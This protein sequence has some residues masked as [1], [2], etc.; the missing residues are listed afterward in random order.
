MR[1]FY[2]E[3]GFVASSKSSSTT[4]SPNRSFTSDSSEPGSADTKFSKP[5]SCSTFF[6]SAFSVFDTHRDSSSTS[7]KPHI[8]HGNGWTSA[9]KKIVAGGSMRRIQECVLGTGKT[10]ISNTPGDIWLL[11]ACYKISQDNSSG[12]AAATNALAAFNHD[13]C[14]FIGFDAIEDS[15]LTS[16]VSWGCMLRSSQMLVAQALLFH[17]LGRSWRKPLDKLINAQQHP[18]VPRSTYLLEGLIAPCHFYQRISR[19]LIALLAVLNL[20]AQ[21]SCGEWGNVSYDSTLKTN[22]HITYYLSVTPILVAK[23]NFRSVLYIPSL[24]AT[25]TF[26]QSLGILGGKPGASTYIVGVQDEDAFYLDPHE[27]QP[28]VNVSRDV[29]EANTSS[30]HCNVVRH[31]PLDFIDPSLAI[32]FY[33]RDKVKNLKYKTWLLKMNIQKNSRIDGTVTETIEARNKLTT[34]KER[35]C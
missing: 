31:I 17:R 11:G 28:V 16:D 2:C 6:A 8:R 10:G 19:G 12:D 21:Y 34:Q 15:K 35:T 26:P 1:P 22:N 25:F 7:E 29:V 4:D 20:V 33:C 5:S 14:S 3:R 9:V 30:Y 24:Q 27:V 13:F 18:Q 32:G 23:H